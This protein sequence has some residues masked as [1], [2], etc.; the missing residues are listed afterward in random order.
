MIHTKVRISLGGIYDEIG[1]VPIIPISIP[2]RQDINKLVWAAHAKAEAY[3]DEIWGWPVSY[4]PESQEPIPYSNMQF[5]PAVFTIGV[6]PIWFV[7]FTWEHG[8]DQTPTMLLE[9]ENLVT[10][11]STEK[12]LER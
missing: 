8:K 2:D 9:N 10:T 1:H 5:T 7:S 6:H 4:T 12:E 11:R 3:E